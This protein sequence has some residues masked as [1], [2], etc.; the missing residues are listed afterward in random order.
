MEKGADMRKSPTQKKLTYGIGEWYGHL[1]DRLRPA[2]AKEFAALGSRRKVLPC[3]SKRDFMCSK[4]GGVCSLRAYELDGD[5][6]AARPVGP[7]VTT[8]PYRFEED[9]LIYRW[10]SSEI[11]G[12]ERPILLG[13]IDFLRSVTLAENGNKTS[14]RED[15]GRI[16]NVLV[17]PELDHL[18]WCALELQ[19]VYFSGAEMGKEFTAVRTH[20]G[21]WP[22]YPAGGRR[23]D[24]RS[25]GPKRLMPQ[26]QI[27]VPALRR[28]G[29]K[30][31]VLVDEPFF[32][33]LGPMEPA[34]DVSNGD[35]VWFVVKY[36]EDSHAARLAASF[37]CVTTLERAVEGLTAGQP[38][39]LP[40]FEQRILERARQQAPIGLATSDRA[41]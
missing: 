34:D 20:E 4:A 24:Y 33:A 15:V 16:D 1:F 31:A 13:Q 17:H 8:C 3:K 37:T 26:L 32:G 19:A 10:I 36:I 9:N 40:T 14:E 23:P 35:I 25:S 11:L 22:P 38:V 29:K 12:T 2:E 7:L 30:M 39:S 21:A 18:R 5:T 6:G 27:K 28:W 41:Q